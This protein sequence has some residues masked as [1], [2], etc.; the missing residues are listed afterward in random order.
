MS[1]QD[2]WQTFVTVN[3]T[4][5]GDLGMWDNFEGGEVDSDSLTYG[6][7]GM[8]EKISLGGTKT[9][10]EITVARL[11]MLGR[12]TNIIKALF[13]AVGR[14]SVTIRRVVMDKDGN[15]FEKDGNGAMTY[16]GVLKTVTPPPANSDEGGGNA[17][18][19]ELVITPD[20]TI[21]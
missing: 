16:T 5:L 10:G 4:G 11:Y 20:S 21:A 8:A 15:P 19:I 13:K 6:P 12:D 14:A 9:V 1:R 2:Q 17:S 3:A 7:G 18:M